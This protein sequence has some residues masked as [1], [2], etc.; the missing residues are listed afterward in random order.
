MRGGDRR[1]FFNNFATFL[2]QDQLDSEY[3][4]VEKMPGGQADYYRSLLKTETNPSRLAAL[5]QVG[6]TNY[7]VWQLKPEEV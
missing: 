1:S 4:K 2:G 5:K 3:E 6:L 7:S